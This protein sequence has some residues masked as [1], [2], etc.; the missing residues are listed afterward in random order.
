MQPQ[1]CHGLSYGFNVVTGHSIPYAFF[2]YSTI[3]LPVNY[4]PNLINFAIHSRYESTRASQ[5]IVIEL[6]PRNEYLQYEHREGNDANNMHFPY[7]S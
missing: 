6:L 1:G 3:F 4:N 2:S 5:F 7:P